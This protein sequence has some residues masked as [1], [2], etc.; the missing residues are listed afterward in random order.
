MPDMSSMPNSHGTP[1]THNAPRS[2]SDA[3]AKT[4]PRPEEAK[5]NRSPSVNIRLTPSALVML[6][7]LTVITL[8]F[9]F[10]FGLIIGRGMIPPSTP[11]PLERFMPEAT[12]EELPENILAQEDLNFMQNLRTGGTQ[13]AT[14][15]PINPNPANLTGERPAAV[16]QP[17]AQVNTTPAAVNQSNQRYDYILQAA[18]FKVEEQADALRL[19]LE[20]S[21]LRTR[22]VREPSANGT[23]YHVQ[24]LYRGSEANF[25][26]IRESLPKF[27]IR[28]S[29]LLSKTVV[30]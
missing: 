7:M 15:L 6:T 18:A 28:D 14:A 9:F 30:E 22:L 4:R 1:N 19:K 5:P 11:T 17:V 21:E 16:N 29:I 12:P 2:S 26:R 23:W 20:D 8:S 10:I 27:G 3:T 25:L 24:V 13:S